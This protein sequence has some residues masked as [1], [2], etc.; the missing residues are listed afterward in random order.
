[1]YYTFTVFEKIISNNNLKVIDIEL[2]EIN[3]GSI[4]VV[5]AKKTSER[6]SNIKKIEPSCP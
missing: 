2:N 1:M 6:K 4:E 3:G 5:V